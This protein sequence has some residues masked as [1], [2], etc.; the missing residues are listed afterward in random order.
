MK[1]P[2]FFTCLLLFCLA[3]AAIRAQTVEFEKLHPVWESAG[4]SITDYEVSDDGEG[5]YL[6]TAC[7]FLFNPQENT[8]VALFRLDAQG[9]T[10]WRLTL[11]GASGDMIKAIS[12]TA[13]GNF[14]LAGAHWVQPDWSGSSSGSL[15]WLIKMDPDGNILWEKDIDPGWFYG[16]PT[17]VFEQADGSIMVGGNA[18][19]YWEYSTFLAK[20]DESGNYKWLERYANFSDFSHCSVLRDDAGNYFSGGTRDNLNTGA[21]QFGMVKADAY[22]T[23]I[24]SKTYVTFPLFS[25][26]IYPKLVAG[27]DGGFYLTGTDFDPNQ[28]IAVGVVFRIGANGNQIWKKYYTAPNGQDG[29]FYT[30]IATSDGGVLALTET[31]E[32]VKYLPD[33]AQDFYLDLNPLLPDNVRLFHLFRCADGKLLLTGE[34]SATAMYCLKLDDPALTPV[35]NPADPVVLLASPN[36][37]SG[38]TK[39]SGLEYHAFREFRLTDAQG[40]LVQSGDMPPEATWDL[41]SLAPG[42]YFLQLTGQFSAEQVKLIRL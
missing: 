33:G 34:S 31:N 36:P 16:W 39:L 11:G 17:A 2:L 27:P 22:G 23:Q 26:G 14:M 7:T 35:T 32:L 30:S 10:L 28:N 20:F 24:F 19:M 37:T 13:D 12:R 42:A 40:R 5:G 1:T 21:T 15:I 6:I 8:D 3:G 29:I 18:Y 25:L 38:A 41:G 4:F 9:D